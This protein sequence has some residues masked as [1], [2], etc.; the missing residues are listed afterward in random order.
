MKLPEP[1]MPNRCPNCGIDLKKV[2]S[3]GGRSI[4]ENK[5]FHGVVIPIL[6]EHTGYNPA[7]M[8]EILKAKFL[9]ETR[10][11]DTVH[12]MAEIQYIKPTSSL[13]TIEFEAFL[14]KI[15]MWAA[16]ELSCVVPLPNEVNN[17]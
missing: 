16:Q 5:F 12:G 13:T 9:S 11:I 7:E 4:A 1:T 6:A 14:D 17:D 8:K 10:V 2:C 15:R 3:S